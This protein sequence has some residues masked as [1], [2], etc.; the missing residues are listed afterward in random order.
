MDIV[1]RPERPEDQRALDRLMVE[2]QDHVASLDSFG[3]NR[4]GASFDVQE[5]FKNLRDK[6]RNGDGR[7]FVAESNGNVI[8]FVA[9]SVMETSLQDLLEAFS[10]RDGQVHELIVASGQRGK[11]VGAGLMREMEK[12]F[13]EQGCAFVKVGC[14]APNTSAHDFYEKCGFQDRYV[15]LM[16]KLKAD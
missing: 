2:L 4:P 9:G 15:V 7:I 10:S 11:G 3:R 13:S 12:Y 1:V 8:G 6:L 5:Y 14:F 16:K